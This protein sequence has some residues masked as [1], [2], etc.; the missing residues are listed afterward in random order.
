MSGA[1]H[2]CS[3]KCACE[4]W[5]WNCFEMPVCDLAYKYSL[6]CTEDF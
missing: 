3:V 1:A 4:L 2:V 5:Q 6:T